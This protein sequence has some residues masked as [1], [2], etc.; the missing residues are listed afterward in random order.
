MRNLIALLLALA[1][2]AP[3]LGANDGQIVSTPTVATRLPVYR[4]SFILSSGGGGSPGN[5]KIQSQDPAGWVSQPSAGSDGGSWSTDLTI[6]YNTGLGLGHT[7]AC[8][9]SAMDNGGADAFGLPGLTQPYTASGTFTVKV[10]WAGGESF[11]PE[12]GFVISC[13][14]TS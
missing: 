11:F 6:G 2:A 9:A 5:Y 7:V 10:A 3:V 8:V 14:Q 1:V 12:N 13:I 4:V